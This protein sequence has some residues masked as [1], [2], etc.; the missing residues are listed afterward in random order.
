LAGRRDMRTEKV[1]I[2][3]QSIETKEVHDCKNDARA[4]P[5]QNYIYVL[6]PTD[7]FKSRLALQ[8]E[9]EILA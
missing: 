6:L 2:A 4:C 5:W 3:E 7:N 1:E 8:V 9:E